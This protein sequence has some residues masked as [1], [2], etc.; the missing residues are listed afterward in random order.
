MD[1]LLSCHKCGDVIVKDTGSEAKVRSRVLVLKSGNAYAVCK[2]CGTDIQVPLQLDTEMMKS[3]RKSPR[4]FI[5]K[6]K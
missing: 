4:L 2:G 6:K 3:L 1:Y 5:S